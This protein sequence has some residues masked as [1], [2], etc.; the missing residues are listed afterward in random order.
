MGQ[1]GSLIRM[2]VYLVRHGIAA[3]RDVGFIDDA[4]RELTAEGFKKMQRHARALASLG[5]QIEEIWTSP[6]VRARQTADVLATGLGGRIAIHQ[7]ADLAP[8]GDFDVIRRRLAQ[9]SRLSGVALVGHEPFLGEFTSYLLGG[10][11]SLMIRFKKG[12]V[13]LVE[14]DDFAPPLRGELCWLMTPKQMGMMG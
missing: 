11:R 12:G 7:V 5:V 3:P 10:P 1:R 4:G 13:A 8:D 9:H 2:Q 14:I 6:L